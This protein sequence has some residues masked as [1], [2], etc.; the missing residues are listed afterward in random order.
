MGNIKEKS[1]DEIWNSAKAQQVR[2]MVKSC[3]KNCWMIGSVSPAM[4]KNMK[5]PLK[6]VIKNKWFSKLA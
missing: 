2:A 6:W 1:F 3:D 4:K 5:V